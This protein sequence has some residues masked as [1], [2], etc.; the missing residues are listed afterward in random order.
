MEAA[1]RERERAQGLRY[2]SRGRKKKKREML[3][4]HPPS[5]PMATGEGCGGVCPPPLPRS[6]V[7]GLYV[8]YYGRRRRKPADFA[9]TSR[10]RKERGAGKS[11]CPT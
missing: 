1:A 9:L 3:S 7:V 5:T 8:A 6:V 11:L 2:T 10:Q 4:F